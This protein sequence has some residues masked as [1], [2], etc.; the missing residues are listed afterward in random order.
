[1]T[2]KAS[3]SSQP[4]P[5]YLSVVFLFVTA[6]FATGPE[7]RTL[8]N[9]QGAPDGATSLSNLI[10]D[11]AGNFYGTTYYGGTGNCFP[12]SPGSD[13]GTVFELIRPTTRG[14]NWTEKVL[15]RF[16]GGSD[17]ASPQGGL[18]F[19]QKG[20]LYG[21]TAYGGSNNCTWSYVTGCGT[22]FR[23]SP[24]TAPGGSWTE[25]LL[26]VFQGSPDGYQPLAG[27]TFDEKGNL[28]GTTL[29]GGGGYCNGYGA[30][31]GSV[32]ELSPPAAQGSPWTEAVL[33]G[34][35]G[36]GGSYY[37]GA[38]PYAGV[39][40]DRKGNLYG[41]TSAGGASRCYSSESDCG[42]IIFQLAPPSSK[43]NPWKETIIY[44]F[45]FNSNGSYP[46]ADLISDL[47]GN[48]YGTT[49]IGGSGNCLDDTGF[50]EGCGT[51]FS[52]SPPASGG[53]W[54]LRTLYSFTAGNDG[55]YPWSGLSFD[56][57]GN[58]YGTAPDG[59]GRGSCTD[60]A[61]IGLGCGTVY[62]LTPPATIGGTWTETTL[63]SFSGGSNG[64]TPYGRVL[65]HQGILYG[66]TTGFGNGSAGSL[67]TV[68][69]ILP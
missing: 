8:Y 31:C 69:G 12:S 54:T 14:G 52:L 42:G 21:T 15:Y 51:I 57:K 28:Y 23:L 45:E 35:N 2:H 61:G 20:N 36:L 64:G 26:Y 49:E 3:R 65:L 9:F 18:I 19:D 24:P 5:V 67:G 66:T 32:F 40:F 16:R 48:L 37:D 7:E 53:P 30:G 41:T 34:F 4:L 13:C 17:G 44:D 6:A 1:M 50:T 38:G 59:G 68:F 22:V 62:K 10:S 55:A 43:G 11:E 33:Y 47:S 29:L 39:V 56:D 27:L 60:I 58:L 63:Y 25:S 46:L